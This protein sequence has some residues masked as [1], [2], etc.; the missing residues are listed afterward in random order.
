[1]V[2]KLQ[3]FQCLA[4]QSLLDTVMAYKNKIK[5]VLETFLSHCWH[6]SISA[7]CHKEIVSITPLLSLF[8][9]N[10]DPN[11]IGNWSW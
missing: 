2:L 9:R 3:I 7:R 6:H 1:M 11:M 5:I 10:T 8:I 4:F